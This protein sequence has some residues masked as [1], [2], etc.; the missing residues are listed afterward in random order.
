M[1]F[2]AKLK[3]LYSFAFKDGTYNFFKL[4]GFIL[5]ASALLRLLANFIRTGRRSIGI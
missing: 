5:L 4:I 2:E 1:D 3:E